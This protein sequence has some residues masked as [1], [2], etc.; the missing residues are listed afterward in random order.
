M[1]VQERR[2]GRDGEER[3]TGNQRRR[4]QEGD[5]YKT[6][7]KKEEG[8]EEVRGWIITVFNPITTETAE[9]ENEDAFASHG[10]LTAPSGC[11]CIHFYI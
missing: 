6:K 2:V 4:K 10:G 8:R 3:T 5:L 1:G 11:M 7:K 9:D